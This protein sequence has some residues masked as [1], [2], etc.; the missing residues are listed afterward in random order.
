MCGVQ[1]RSGSH[2]REPPRSPPRPRPHGSPLGV[3]PRD[4][5]SPMRNGAPLGRRRGWR[6]RSF[7]DLRSRRKQGR[8]LQER[9]LHSWGSDARAASASVPLSPREPASV[10]LP[11]PPHD[12]LS[13]PCRTTRSSERPGSHT[14][15]SITSAPPSLRAWGA[16]RSQRPESASS[17]FGCESR[18]PAPPPP[19]PALVP[20]RLPRQLRRHRRT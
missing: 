1:P 14:G 5:P 16:A 8:R 17:T 4:A 11:P 10:S 3:A 19:G 9:R 6:F 13:R 12:S 7:R 15:P 2:T 20:A 18:R